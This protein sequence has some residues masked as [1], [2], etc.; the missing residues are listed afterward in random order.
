MD[1]CRFESCHPRERFGQ[2]ALESTAVGYPP[3]HREP[4]NADIDF[5]GLRNG[6]KSAMLYGTARRAECPRY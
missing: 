3:E 4:L 2:Y 6:A 1:T 5:S